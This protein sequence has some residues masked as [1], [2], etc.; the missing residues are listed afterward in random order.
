MVSTPSRHGGTSL[1]HPQSY[2][3]NS[4]LLSSLGITFVLKLWELWE[5]KGVPPMPLAPQ[6]ISITKHHDHDPL[7]RSLG[8]GFTF[9]LF[10]P[11]LGEMIQ[12]DSYFSNGLKPPTGISLQPAFS[13]QKTWHVIFFL[14]T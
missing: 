11:L 5:S 14:A 12:F 4:L 9:F 3:D 8:G 2:D 6:E 13:R 7:I 10:S 1:E